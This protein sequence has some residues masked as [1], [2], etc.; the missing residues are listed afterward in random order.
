MHRPG[1]PRSWLQPRLWTRTNPLLR[2]R[3]TRRLTFAPS[4]PVTPERLLA[5]IARSRGKMKMLKE[6]TV[7]ARIPKGPWPDVR[8][9]L[10]GLLAE[11]A[12]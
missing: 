10:T 7:E 9:A 6:F 4:T 8:A 12:R 2:K 3:S 11:L 5:V 1:E